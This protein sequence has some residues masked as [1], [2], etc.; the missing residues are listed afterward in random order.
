MNYVRYKNELLSLGQLSTQAIH[1]LQKE[2]RETG[3]Y[4]TEPITQQR[5]QFVSPCVENGKRTSRAH[6]RFSSSTGTHQL[7]DTYLYDPDTM[8][9]LINDKVEP[10]CSSYE[11]DAF[12]LR[13]QHDNFGQS[14]S[15]YEG[16]ILLR[17][18]HNDEGNYQHLLGIY[19]F[20]FLIEQGCT[21]QGEYRLPIPS[22]G[23]RYRIIDNA[24]LS[25]EGEPELAIELQC[26][27]LTDQVLN[28]RIDD[29]HT[30]GIPQIWVLAGNAGTS[31]AMKT[32]CN[33]QG[34]PVVKWGI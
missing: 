10:S 27:L 6:G 20:S 1:E 26:S 8:L 22:Q 24:V 14:R 33:R 30:A 29:Y 2:S 7:Q 5:V 3:E 31:D 19:D 18:I 25:S 23:N 16:N 11:P 4:P 32:A 13:A 28:Q 12:F 34:V 15:H 17:D 21:I 9:A